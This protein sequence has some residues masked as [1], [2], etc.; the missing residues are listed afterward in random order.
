MARKE[1]TEFS[2]SLQIMHFP[3]PVHKQ[4]LCNSAARRLRYGLEAVCHEAVKCQKFLT[5]KENVNQGIF[6]SAATS[7]SA[8]FIFSQFLKFE[9][10]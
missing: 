3:A 1:G 7:V 4:P 2:T 5:R 8:N 10:S 6:P 9:V